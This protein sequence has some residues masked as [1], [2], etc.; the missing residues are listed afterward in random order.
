MYL[1]SFKI[2]I[3]FTITSVICTVVLF[4]WKEQYPIK[5]NFHVDNITK[6]LF[7]VV[8]F[9]ISY[10]VIICFHY[11][12]SAIPLLVMKLREIPLSVKNFIAPVFCSSSLFLITYFF[13]SPSFFF[14][15]FLPVSLNFLQTFHRTL[16]TDVMSTDQLLHRPKPKFI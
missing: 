16:T 13:A 4:T 6:G 5:D 14:T 8:L 3:S 9:N 15:P 10:F 2:E 1:L 7:Q 11:H 12:A